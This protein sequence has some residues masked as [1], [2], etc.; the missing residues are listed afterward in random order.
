[1]GPP[2]PPQLR[3]S[4]LNVCLSGA[5]QVGPPLPP[6]LRLIRKRAPVPEARG[7]YSAGADEVKSVEGLEFARNHAFHGIRTDRI[8]LIGPFDE[9]RGVAG[10]ESP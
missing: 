4:I 2:Q 7:E 9:R 10:C 8:E 3:T 1:M 5:A 6:F